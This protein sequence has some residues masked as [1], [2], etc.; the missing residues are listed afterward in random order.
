MWSS[1]RAARCDHQQLLQQWRWTSPP[2]PRWP[3]ALAP[4]PA[5]APAAPPGTRCRSSPRHRPPP[6]RSRR[7]AYGRR[8]PPL[9]PS[10]P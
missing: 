1:S 8:A 4:S 9:P 7:L 2:S 5:G 6:R 10:L 3:P